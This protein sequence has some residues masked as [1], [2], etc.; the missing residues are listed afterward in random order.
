V[1]VG[2]LGGGWFDAFLASGVLGGFCVGG[3]FEARGEWE[4]SRL[5]R[6]MTLYAAL[7]RFIQVTVLNK[8]VVGLGVY[9]SYGGLGPGDSSLFGIGFPGRET[10]EVQLASRFGLE[11][12]DRMRVRLIPSGVEVVFDDDGRVESVQ[13]G[14]PPV[15]SS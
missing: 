10:V 14:C 5:G 7:N 4:A 2:L 6:S 12:P 1:S 15:V 9:F 13:T 8:R 11:R 3:E